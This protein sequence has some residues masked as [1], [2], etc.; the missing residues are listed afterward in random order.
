MY[1]NLYFRKL[2]DYKKNDLMSF[3]TTN[4]NNFAS[5]YTTN[6]NDIINNPDILKPFKIP[7]NNNK[8]YNN[9][10]NILFPFKFKILKSTLFFYILYF[11][12]LFFSILKYV[13]LN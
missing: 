4:K 10:Y 6:K 3:Y 7:I 5:F 11:L 1:N 9:D 13:N 2:L 8:I 12:I